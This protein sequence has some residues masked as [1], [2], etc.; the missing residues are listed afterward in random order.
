M[1]LNLI[2]ESNGLKKVNMKEKVDAK[3]RIKKIALIIASIFIFGFLVQ[4]ISNF[5]GNDKI[6]S[7]LNYA[8]VDNKKMEYKYSGTGDYTVVFDGA[9]GTNLNEWHYVI[10][11]LKD[12]GVSVKT[13]VY[14]RR[15]YGFSDAPSGETTEKQ[16]EN[17]KILLRK[18]GVSGKLILVG[19]QYGSLVMTDFAKLYPESVAGMVLVNPYSESTIKSD[20]FKKEIRYDYYKSKVEKSG[21]QI[22]LTKIIDKLNFDYH[23]Q[24]FEDSLSPDELKEFDILKDQS[25][26]RKAVN[27]ELENLYNYSADNQ[28]SG[29]LDGKPLYIITNNEDE[30]VQD[31]GSKDL[32]TVYLTKSTSPVMSVTDP[33][34]IV[35]GISNVV[36]SAKK[37]SKGAGNN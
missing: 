10:D 29:M 36:K 35:T 4:N 30:A 26:Y 37:I 7:S 21:T 8:K 13:F 11:G 20:E 28:I 6:S 22:A 9:I 32:T 34:T 16:A 19:E 24:E 17:L 14:N 3:Q 31:I 1:N 5:I 2:P 23:V 15:G 18:A 27:N 25:A 33:S 12:K